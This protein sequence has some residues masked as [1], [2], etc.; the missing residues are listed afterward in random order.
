[1][2]PTVSAAA[3]TN[4]LDTTSA[5]SAINREMNEK[6]VAAQARAT[7]IDYVDIATTPI[8]Q[9][10]V[11]L[12]DFQAA[13]QA[14]V[15]PFFR[16]GHKL[17]IAVAEPENMATTAYL[18]TF[19]QNLFEVHL[20][21]ASREGIEAKL[22]ELEELNTRH[23][24]TFTN[25]DAEKN[26]KN[27][28][29]EIVNLEHLPDEARTLSAAATLNRLLVGALRTTASDIHFQSE[30][31]ALLIRFRI[32][33]LLQDILRFDKKTGEQVLS[34]LKYESKLRIN[35][36]NTPQDGRLSFTA[37]GRSVDLRVATLPTQF[38]EGA[39]CRILDRERK[40]RSFE[41]LGFG[42][43]DLKNILQSSDRHDGLIIVTGPT[44]SGKTTTLYTLLDRINHPDRKIAT[45]EDP[46]EY[47]LARVAQSQ[48][49]EESGYTFAGG[50][51]AL[52]RQD[53]DIIM[54]GE[55][56]DRETAETAAQ[57][58]M[59]GHLVLTTLHTNSTVEAIP[60]LINLG[61]PPYLIAASLSCVIAQ[62]LVRKIHTDCAKKVAPS[63]K[64]EEL[65]RSRLA[66]LHAIDPSIEVEVP[67]TIWQPVGCSVCSGTGYH[68]QL[69]LT[70]SFVMTNHIRELIGHG[71][72]ANQIATHLASTTHFRT[73]A[74]DGILKVANGL[75]T[76]A[77][78]MRVT[79]LFN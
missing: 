7:N 2:P 48:I 36:R 44:G 53:P 50:L 41:E 3:N 20:A 10:M 47:H 78:I 71:A 24:E 52:L 55:I 54:V 26:L 23:L 8:N 25:Q 40:L 16:V 69:A 11:H 64:E 77:E 6:R 13:R 58:A 51:R 66:A 1:M 29:E 9:D 59:T 49:D 42:D 74:D 60:R 76:I 68:G 4:L 75:T 70:E 27:Y 17:R 46:I 19:R 45:L 65:L 22:T 32:D 15:I 35:V 79:N 30:E 28:E 57:A 33:G 56:R 62:R 67:T 5:L 31:D 37:S 63:A 39:V 18:A 12:I 21:L 72:D 73:L 14:L 61:L 43:H 38:G 34:Q